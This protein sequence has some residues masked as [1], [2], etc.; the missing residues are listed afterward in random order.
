MRSGHHRG[1]LLRGD[2]GGIWRPFRVHVPVYILSTLRH[3]DSK[4]HVRP[5]TGQ[6]IPCER[7]HAKTEILENQ[8]VTF[9]A[10]FENRDYDRPFQHFSVTLIGFH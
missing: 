3:F 7:R 10:S 9:R 4:L 1:S 2:R 5:K 8:E 6:L